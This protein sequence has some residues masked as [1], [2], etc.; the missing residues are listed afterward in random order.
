MFFGTSFSFPV[1]FAVRTASTEESS[2]ELL[3]GVRVAWYAAFA[4]LTGIREGLCVPS[5]E[6]ALGVQY[7]IRML[8]GIL[9]MCYFANC[10]KF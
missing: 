6:L 9:T 8:Y 5:S 3:R 4:V 1:G 10:R 2:S 7:V